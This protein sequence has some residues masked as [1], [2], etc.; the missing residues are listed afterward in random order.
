MDRQERQPVVESLFKN[1]AARK[2]AEE[3]RKFLETLDPAVHWDITHPT[4]H[5]QAEEALRTTDWRTKNDRAKELLRFAGFDEP[6]IAGTSPRPG[7]QGFETA[8]K[9]HY[10]VALGKFCKDLLLER[11][12]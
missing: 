9:K 2:V 4:Y 3:H 1:E 8:F 7:Q 12:K 5:K 11:N 10:A 6:S